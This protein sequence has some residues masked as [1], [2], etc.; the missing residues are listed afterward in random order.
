[1]KRFIVTAEPLKFSALLLVFA[2]TLLASLPHAA[3]GAVV[4][5]ACLGLLEISGVVRLYRLRRSEL[6]FSIVC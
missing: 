5:S 4:T 2:P 3:L 1:M 6:A